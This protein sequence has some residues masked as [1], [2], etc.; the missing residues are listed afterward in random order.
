VQP[1]L[2]CGSRKFLAKDFLYCLAYRRNEQDRLTELKGFTAKKISIS[3]YPQVKA[4]I[5]ATNHKLKYHK[6]ERGEHMKTI[7]FMFA[8]LVL[9]GSTTALFAE[10]SGLPPNPPKKTGPGTF[11]VG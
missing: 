10:G 11:L 5:S 3:Q 1:V 8:L 2:I 4:G 6:I 9:V 7:R